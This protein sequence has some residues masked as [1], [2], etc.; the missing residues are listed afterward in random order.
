M[1]VLARAGVDVARLIHPLAH[2]FIDPLEANVWYD[3]L[4]K[5]DTCM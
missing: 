3:V 4:L 2:Q 1:W 5:L